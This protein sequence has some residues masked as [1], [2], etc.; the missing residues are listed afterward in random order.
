MIKSTPARQIRITNTTCAQSFMPQVAS[1]REAVSLQGYQSSQTH[2]G[3]M[4]P[5]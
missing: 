5:V 2:S 4:K 3:I 1:L